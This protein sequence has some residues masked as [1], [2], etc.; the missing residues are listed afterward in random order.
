MNAV[1]VATEVFGKVERKEGKK[2][3]YALHDVLSKRSLKLICHTGLS[4]YCVGSIG[5]SVDC[6]QFRVARYE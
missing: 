6:R 2:E 1:V 5:V 4:K 3:V